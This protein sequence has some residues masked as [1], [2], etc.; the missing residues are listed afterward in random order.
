MIFKTEGNTALHHAIRPGKR[1]EEVIKVANNLS[2]LGATQL[3]NNERLTPL[4]LASNNRM[5]SVVKDFIKRPQCTKEQ[6]IDALE[7]LGASIS[8][9]YGFHVFC[10]YDEFDDDDRLASDVIM[11]DRSLKAFEYMKR[12]MEERFQDLSH[13][14]LKQPMEPVEA[15]QNRKESQTLEELALIEGDVDAILMESLI[16]RERILGIDNRELLHPIREVALYHNDR[17]NFDICVGLCRHAI[18]I[19]HRGIIILTK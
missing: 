13:P 3:Y 8:T 4:L 14:L 2:T 9:Y 15:Y 12:G 5:V 17:Q 1:E 16:I 7:L 18:E 19:N 11:N 6:R 10:D